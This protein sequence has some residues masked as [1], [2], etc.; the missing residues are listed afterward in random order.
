MHIQDS[1]AWFP[2]CLLFSGAKNL[3]IS[4]HF[5]TGFWQVQLF[6]N[7]THVAVPRNRGALCQ[8]GE[9]YLVEKDEAYV[10]GALR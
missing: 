7:Q 5:H 1:I 3:Q 9:L 8:S 10:F 4:P 6:F 2:N